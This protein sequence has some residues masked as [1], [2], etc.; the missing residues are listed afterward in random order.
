LARLPRDAIWNQIECAKRALFS[1]NVPGADVVHDRKKIRANVNAFTEASRGGVPLSSQ[2]SQPVN[3]G[4]GP[5]RPDGPAPV[6]WRV[7]CVPSTLTATRRDIRLSG[8][9]SAL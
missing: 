5:A 9:R 1:S 8:G 3:L 4:F 6:A 2:G 7:L